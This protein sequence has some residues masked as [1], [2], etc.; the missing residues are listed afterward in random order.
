LTVVEERSARL[1]AARDGP[2][3]VLVIDDNPLDAELSLAEL[4]RAGI[5]ADSLVAADET[6]L[7]A[8][9]ATFVPDV[10]LCESSRGLDGL[11]AQRIVREKCASPLIFVTGTM[12]EARA[13][14]ALES[15]AVDYILKPHLERLPSAVQHAVR[16][17][18]KLKRL[19]VSLEDSADQ[20]RGQAE[21]L[22]ALWRIVNNPN[23]RG[24]EL[25]LA[26]LREAAAAMRPPGHAYFGVLGHVEGSQYIIDAFSGT[27]GLDGGAARRLIRAGTHV[28]YVEPLPVADL[29]ANHAQSPPDLKPI[30]KLPGPPHDLG[31]QNQITTEF[32]AGGTS[33]V[34]TLG[35]LEAPAMTPFNSD[36]YAYM[37]VLGSVYARQLEVGKMEAWLRESGLRSREHAE[38]LE[39]LWQ[40]AHN[41]TLRDQELEFVMLRQAAAAIRPTQRFHGVLARIEEDEVVVIGVGTD[42][43]DGD[44]RDAL[45]K[46]GTRTPIEKTLSS[47]VSRT[48]GW[49]DLAGML[50]VPGQVQQLGWRA[51]ISTQFDAGE[52][53]YS[54]TF[55][56]HEPTTTA[57]GTEDFSFLEVLA[58]SFACH[59]EVNQLE[60]TLRGEMERSQEQAERLEALWQVVNNPTLH[61]EELVLA[62]L[63]QAAAAIRPGQQ[64]LGTLG[65]VE[66]N[67]VVALAVWVDPADTDSRAALLKP[68]TRTPIE[69]TMLSPGNR[70]R[71]WDDLTTTENVSEIINAL[72]WRSMITTQ[73]DACGSRYTLTFGSRAP[74]TTAFDM[75]DAAF[76]E[77]LS[78]SFAKQLQVHQLEDSLGNE[79]GR[80]RHHAERLE[81]LWKIVSKPS[82]SGEEMVLAMMRQGAEAIRPDQDYRG[83]LWRI[84]GADM[85]LEAVAGS[86]DHLL[87]ESRMRLGSARPLVGTTIGKVLAGNARTQSWDDIRSSGDASAPTWS[88]GTR[89]L[90][91]TTFAAGGTDWVL[92]FGSARATSTAIGPQDHAYIEVLASFFANHVQQ[93]WQFDRLAFQQAHDVL[94]GLLN[95]SQFRS[96]TR[97]ASSASS[98]YAIIIVDVNAFREINESYGSMIGDALL[99]E[100][101]S[102]LRQ[103]STGEEI[104]GRI[105]GD[106]FAIYVPNPISREFVR[107]RALEFAEAFARS[108]STGDHDGT[109]FIARTASL[110]IAVAPED[111][112]Q[113]DTILAHADAAL[114]TAKARGHGS[115]VF[116]EA[117]MEGDAQRNATLR[118]ELT[119][120]IVSD[121][122]TLYYQPHVEISTGDVT[123]CEALIRWNHPTRGLLLPGDFIP[124]A[125]QIGF[126]A[127]IDAW[128]M[129]HAFAAAN[130][131]SALRPGFR[132]FFNLSGRQAGNPRLIRAFTD[133]ARGGVSLANIGVE[134]TESDA[135]RDVAATRR[136]CRAL[137]RLNVR[138][139]IDD[140][141]TG[142]SSL[143]SLKMLPVDIVK[144]DRSFIAGVLSDKHDETIAETIISITQHFGFESL[145][146]GAEQPEEIEWLRQHACRYVQGYAISQPLPLEDFKAWLSER[147]ARA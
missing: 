32:A 113:I 20:A 49:D 7:R 78:S 77:V 2:L 73:F 57:F 143:S 27:L 8:A 138:I 125:E 87:G 10:I 80:S 118:N 14:T 130:E 141:G 144:I 74:T 47:Q 119:A 89:S 110:G 86:P 133:A 19:E 9:L 41:P 6:A 123:G 79:E 120:A 97:I 30:L 55:A 132:L 122:F 136:V 29:A 60:R 38:R 108:F 34:L 139:A 99:V 81:A 33:Y 129:Q 90:I 121:Q 135:M 63:G 25:V 75:E 35:S 111:G 62:M 76:I 84:Q 44:P 67:E 52:S 48:Q 116:Y 109:E 59:L 65:R 131:L 83:M 115:M 100:V 28:E 142:Y 88:N 85:V 112:A 58:S 24:Q 68:G 4:R 72:G 37:E 18:R 96:Q 70:T 114:F 26:T 145:A 94:T 140:F 43:D 103:R 69:Q 134:I 101:A 93:R 107:G 45:L 50:N 16:E 95:R 21:R 61:G 82:L 54:L 127:R 42:L 22:E 64:F 36:D 98:C 102:A 128:V 40:I 3:Q 53:R 15:G 23:L 106:I 92:S 124:F 105:A 17:A 91:V 31:L 13:I 66:A 39:A 11:A 1:Q 117:G 137:R 71:G 56:S 147:P 5:L 126:I 146:E 12:S 46:I 104:I 51:A